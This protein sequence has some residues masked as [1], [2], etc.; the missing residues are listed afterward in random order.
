[1]LVV[2]IVKVHFFDACLSTENKCDYHKTRKW[3]TCLNPLGYYLLHFTVNSNKK[4]S[5]RHWIKR[6]SWNWLIPRDRRLAFIVSSVLSD[7][8]LPHSVAWPRLTASRPPSQL[9]AHLRSYGF[10]LSVISVFLGSAEAVLAF[11]TP[12]LV[13]A[14]ASPLHLQPWSLSVNVATHGRL[15]LGPAALW[16]LNHVPKGLWIYH[17][18]RSLPPG[19]P[20]E[21]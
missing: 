1:M 9:A 15:L 3:R 6:A 7:S 13:A 4:A 8:G 14:L 17:L 16:T 20:W 5:F 18:R 19:V 11:V 21:S 2:H 10:L 12:F